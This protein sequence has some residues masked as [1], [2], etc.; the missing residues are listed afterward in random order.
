MIKFNRDV[1][2]HKDKIATKAL[3]NYPDDDILY[4]NS[5]TDFEISDISSIPN[6]RDESILFLEKDI[7]LDNVNSRNI[8]IISNILENKNLYEN[9]TIT[10]NLNKS[11]NTI[12]NKIYYHEDQKGY[13]DDYNFM[14]GSYISKYS[15]IDKDVEIGK[16]C[17]ISRGVEI[18]KNSIIKNNVVIKNAL[19][20]NNVI[21]SDNSSIGTSG[22]GFDLN[23]RGSPYLNPQ[24]GIVIIEDNVNLGSSCTIDRGKLILHLLV[25]FH[26]RQYGT[27]S[28]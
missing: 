18:G 1:F 4:H 3:Q 6:L 22:F 12:L 24:I 5:L 9:I 7:N 21:I 23:K 28:T 14:N 2:S 15:K 17:V 27:H 10:K 26:D 19:I 13:F 20:G 8:H 25:K 11:Y 16:N